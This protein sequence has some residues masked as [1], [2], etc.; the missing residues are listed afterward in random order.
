MGDPEEALSLLGKKSYDLVLSDIQ[1]PV[2]DGF[3][4]MKRVNQDYPGLPVIMITAHGTISDA[5]RAI[6]EGP[7]TT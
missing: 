4:V 2:L 3:E 6:Q 5:V 7:M 1:M